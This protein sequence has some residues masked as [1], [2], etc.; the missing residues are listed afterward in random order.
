MDS[1]ISCCAT[2]GVAEWVCC[3]GEQNTPLLRA[4]ARCPQIHCWHL[5]DER[6]AAFFAL[7]RIQATARAVAV[8][9]GSGTS[10]AALMPAVIEA[11]YQRRPLIIITADTP[12]PTE[13][14][15]S[16]GRIEQDSLFGFYAPTVELHLPCSVSDLP[17]MEALCAEGFPIHVHLRCAEG[18]RR[19]SSGISVADPPPPPRFRGSLVALSQMLRFHTHEGLV[20]VLGELDPT[21][22]EP[23]LW[24][25]RTL[26]VPV[27]ADATSGLRE[28]LATLLL[29]GGDEQLTTTPPPYVLRIGSVPACPFWAALE[30]MDD[31]QVF[32]ITRTGFSGLRR[33]SEVIE[34]DPEQ[35]MK[36]LGDVHAVGDPMGLLSHSRRFAGRM[37]ELL[38]SYPESDAALV[39]AFSRQACL[40]EVM[41]LA[42]PTATHLWNRFAQLQV[43]VF[44]TR[45]TAQAGGADGAISAF[46][47][48]AVDAAFACALVGDI[49]ILRDLAAAPLLPQLPAG[50]RI[51][52]VL[53][54][55][56]AGAATVD[57]K[58]S[59]LHRLAVQPPELDLQEIARLLRAEYYLIRSEAD[60][61]VIEGMDDNT[62]ALLDIQPDT[63]QSRALLLQL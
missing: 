36:A 43:P 29:H 44:Y 39:R 35:I 19:G 23:A 14:T 10:C 8:L 58:D 42:S 32:S 33:P 12:E 37:E 53:N 45:S 46:L 63:D 31:T 24:L 26:R 5:Q 1:L 30:H 16:Y 27:L 17:D 41:H 4:L 55:E 40:A 6:S 62:F 38:L 52:A 15:G 34:G 20:L 61:E 48:N 54:N 56:G 9:A 28:K 3:P 2:A 13:G 18:L 60:F 51:V 49:S 21:E 11:Y 7:G 50:K 22:Q 25:A 47:G 59:A 57:P